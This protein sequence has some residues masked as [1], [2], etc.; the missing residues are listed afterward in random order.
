ML[1]TDISLIDA[2]HIL[3]S[4][5]MRLLETISSVWFSHEFYPLLKRL[6]SREVISLTRAKK[7]PKML[8][9]PLQ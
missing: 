2:G 9:C 7:P 5:L 8:R 4:A 3:F 1:S 6:E